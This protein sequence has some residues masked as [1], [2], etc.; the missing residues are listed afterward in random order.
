MFSRF[1]HFIVCVRFVFQIVFHC[2]GT[3][4]F[5]YLLIR[6]L[7]YICFL[8]VINHID[9][10]IQLSFVCFHLLWI[11]TW[12]LLDPL[13]TLVFNRL[14]ICQNFAPMAEILTFL[15]VIYEGCSVYTSLL[16]LIFFQW[17][18]L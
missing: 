12:E 17:S 10:K 3:S 14:R 2:A 6:Y 18:I 5:V 8:T 15:P 9:V 7:G 13:V 16:T 11:C 4:H 1:I